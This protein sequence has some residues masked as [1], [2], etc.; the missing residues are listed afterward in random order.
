MYLI[1]IEDDF[2]SA[3][4]LREFQGKCENLHGH[5]WLVRV[6]LRGEILDKAGML[7]DFGVAKQYLKEILEELDHKYLND[8][9]PFDR[10][11]PSAENISR[12]IYE[13]MQNALKDKYKEVKVNRVDVWESHRSRATY[14]ES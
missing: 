2:S 11:N 8:V 14:F 6:E 7:I 13:K 10:L 3:H 12:Y 9:S 5:N 4:Q 1:S